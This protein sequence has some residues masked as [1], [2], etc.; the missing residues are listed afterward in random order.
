[1]ACSS[2]RLPALP[3]LPQ[4]P[5]PPPHGPG[6]LSLGLSCPHSTTLFDCL[7]FGSF[8]PPKFCPPE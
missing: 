1:V 4:S 8:C 5:G 2:P 7:V 6:P 3:V